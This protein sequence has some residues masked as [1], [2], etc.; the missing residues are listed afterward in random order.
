MN[1][2]STVTAIYVDGHT[3]SSGRR[4][5]NRRLSKARAEAVTDYLIKGGIPATIIQ[6]RYH[7][8]RYPVVKNTSKANKAQNRRTTVRL[9]RG[10]D[11]GSYEPGDPVD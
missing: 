6:T 11:A 4:I 10:D 9:M 3:D 1:A 2:D 5:Y 8:E 7:G